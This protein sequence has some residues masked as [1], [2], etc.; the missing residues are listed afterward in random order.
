M[1]SNHIILIAGEASGDLHGA[2]LV[3]ALKKQN[4]SLTFSGLGGP[5][6]KAEGVDV[7]QDITQFAVVGFFEVL[8]HYSKF[9]EAF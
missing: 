6:M 4:P 5:K 7:Y 2:H 9:K 3:Q 8:K 1:S